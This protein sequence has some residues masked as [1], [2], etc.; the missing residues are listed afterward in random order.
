MANPKRPD[1][2]DTDEPDDQHDTIK[3]A[4]ETEES[5]ANSF[6][7]PKSA[8]AGKSFAVDDTFQ[9]RVKAIHD[10]EVELVRESVP[11][12][13]TPPTEDEEEP[14]S[15]IPIEEPGAGEPTEGAATMMD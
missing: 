14:L 5:S 8:L 7:V 1:Y 11:A 13:E 10:D 12:E 9:V 3:D 4:E 15:E 2:F 6:L